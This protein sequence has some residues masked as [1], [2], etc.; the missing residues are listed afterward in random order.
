[1][2]VPSTATVPS[3]LSVSSNG[4]GE[5]NTDIPS[6]SALQRYTYIAGFLA[7]NGFYVVRAPLSVPGISQ[8]V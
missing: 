8:S 2:R 1:M 3:L 7:A 4:D 5:C 6:T